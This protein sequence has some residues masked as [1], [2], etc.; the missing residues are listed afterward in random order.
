MFLALGLLGTIPF[1]I[2]LLRGIQRAAMH[3]RYVPGALG[4]WPLGYLSLVAVLSV[5]ES[6]IAGRTVFWVLLIVALVHSSR[7]RRVSSSDQIRDHLDLPPT[8][9]RFELASWRN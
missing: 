1:I 5:T 4:L 9:P 3:V 6:G 7:L 2:A 8:D